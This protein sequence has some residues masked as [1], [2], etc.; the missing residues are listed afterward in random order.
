M[1]RD[2]YGKRVCHCLDGSCEV[3]KSATEALVKAL[4]KA[5]Q[6]L[7]IA[8]RAKSLVYREVRALGLNLDV[9]KERA[10]ERKRYEESVESKYFRGTRKDP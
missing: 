2:H 4:V 8:Q 6:D 10:D 5:E 7:E 3:C 1:A 9:I